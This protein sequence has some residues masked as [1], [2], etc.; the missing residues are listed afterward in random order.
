MILISDR[1]CRTMTYLLS[2]TYGY[3][4]INFAWI[5]DCVT[6]KK[7][8]S[9]KNY[10]LAVGFSKECAGQIENNVHEKNVAKFVDG[11]SLRNLFKD[12]HYL[13]RE[14]L[15]EQNHIFI[16]TWMKKHSILN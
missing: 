13:V 16:S 11:K 9:R 7:L 4:R 6:S 15:N 10:S 5:E 2:I 8:F 14:L 3:E 1:A 12:E